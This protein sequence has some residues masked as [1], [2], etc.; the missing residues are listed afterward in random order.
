MLAC[1][2]DL[3]A[4]AAPWR[5]EGQTAGWR[6]GPGDCIRPLIHPALETRAATDGSRTLIWVRERAAG[7]SS[8]LL[9]PRPTRLAPDAYE[10]AV[11]ECRDWPLQSIWIET[12]RAG[13]TVSTGL[14]GVCPLYLAHAGG[15]LS[16]SWQLMDLDPHLGAD[17]LDEREVMRLLTGRIRYGH[18]TVFS[19][20]KLLSERS[21]AHADAAGLCM[22]YPQE[23]E[24]ALPD[25]LAEGVD[26]E[27]LVKAWE[28]VAAH[29]MSRR[30]LA[31]TRT[32][33]QLS[34]GMDSTNLAISLAI[35]HPGAITAC[36]MLI[37]GDAAAQQITRRRIVVDR[38]P[39]TSDVTVAAS[40]HPALFP[41]GLRRTRP[42]AISPLDEPHLEAADALAQAVRARELHTVVCGFGGDEVARWREPSSIPAPAAVPAWSG[43]RIRDLLGEV[44]EGIAP[45]TVAP[46]TALVALQVSTP[47]YARR[48][49]WT[50]APFTDPDMVDF[51]RR[52][53]LQWRK[54]KRLLH[55]RLALRGLPD[56]VVNPRH[57]E[58]F[59][60]LM[61]RAIHEYATGLLRS[62]GNDLHL[63][64]QGFVDAAALAET[65]ERASI[66]PA[67]ARPYR[68]GL[69]LITAL[70]LS[71]RAL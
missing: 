29:A 47:L 34:G 52:L 36:A 44:N 14:G 27:I 60:P 11:Q 37:G 35:Q 40:D 10:R 55:D 64:D 51:G 67:E 25:E 65:V 1:S 57:P 31:P 46:E 62:W 8:L 71:L 18:D 22:A 33:A 56:D 26:G 17:A 58:N 23:V 61:D 19:T 41:G 50:L 38:F 39:F 16:G 63:V 7:R 66:G 3:E 15:T 30:P 21:T 24:R 20:V 9:S 48:G 13:A 68:T 69:F 59:G 32:A 49:L 6:R 53:P 43:P 2:I 28:A 54:D 70:E 5:W 12:D 45:T 4:P 42:E